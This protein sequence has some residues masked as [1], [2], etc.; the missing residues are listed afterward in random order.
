M[1]PPAFHIR[2]AVTDDTPAITAIWQEFM[3]FHAQRDRHFTRADDGHRRFADFVSG[4]MEHH[5]SCVAVADQAG[6]VVGYC[7]AMISHYPPVFVYDT[8]GAISDLA[9]RAEFR[10]QGI[11]AALVRHACGWFADRD[12]RRIELRVATTNE[13]STAFWRKM[14]FRP[15]MEVLYKNVP[16]LTAGAPA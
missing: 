10:R 12:I 2:S 4:R 15:Y 13:A 14:G 5:N 11:G 7:L 8:Y 3:D 1:T 9:V 16:R 6:Q